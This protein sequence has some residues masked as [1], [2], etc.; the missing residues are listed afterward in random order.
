[1]L[2]VR[3]AVSGL[4]GPS[5]VRVLLEADAESLLRFKELRE[6]YRN[7]TPDEVTR[8][9]RAAVFAAAQ[10]ALASI[11]AIAAHASE[12]GFDVARW[13]EAAMKS[14]ALVRAPTVPGFFSLQRLEHWALHAVI[15]AVANARIH[16][17]PAPL[18]LPPIPPSIP[19]A[20]GVRCG[21]AEL[22]VS[23]TWPEVAKAFDDRGWKDRRITR[24]GMRWSR[25]AWKTVNAVDSETSPECFVGRWVCLRV[26]PGAAVEFAVQVRLTGT[27]SEGKAEQ[28]ELWLNNGG[29]NFK[30]VVVGV[31]RAGQAMPISEALLARPAAWR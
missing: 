27:S 18:M 21:A 23:V 9:E 2:W 1:M 20:A 29:S 11:H 12:P 7:G 4:D 15:E 16:A 6:A 26:R 5:A 24:V 22:M 31:V 10:L 30:Q 14:I 3:G 19:I 17:A 8:C 28:A 13:A 25:D